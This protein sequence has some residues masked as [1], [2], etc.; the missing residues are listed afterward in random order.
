LIISKVIVNA[1]TFAIDLPQIIHIT[2]K[3]NII[4]PSVQ[5]GKLVIGQKHAYVFYILNFASMTS[6]FAMQISNKHLSLYVCKLC[7][8]MTWRLP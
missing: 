3:S 1:I 4:E 2:L 6:L 7:L 8:C 5:V